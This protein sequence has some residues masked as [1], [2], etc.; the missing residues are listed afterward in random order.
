MKAFG[1]AI[2]FAGEDWTNRSI[3]GPVPEQEGPLFSTMMMTR[4]IFRNSTT[5]ASPKQHGRTPSRKAHTSRQRRRRPTKRMSLKH[6]LT[7]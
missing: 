6:A 1:L 7:A 5:S 2:S 3:A 4:L